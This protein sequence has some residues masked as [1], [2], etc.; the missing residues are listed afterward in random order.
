VTFSQVSQ[1]PRTKKKAHDAL[2]TIP[3]ARMALSRTAPSERASR[4]TFEL[5]DVCAGRWQSYLEHALT[6]KPSYSGATNGGSVVTDIVAEVALG[7]YSGSGEASGK[8]RARRV[9]AITHQM[10]RRSHSTRSLSAE[11]EWIHRRRLRTR[12][13]VRDA[14]RGADVVSRAV[15]MTID[16]RRRAPAVYTPQA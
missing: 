9:S 11:S 3:L 15:L 8:V 6:L 1:R 5:C 10:Q 12:V 2:H 4:E 16:D 7:R 13:H 14:A